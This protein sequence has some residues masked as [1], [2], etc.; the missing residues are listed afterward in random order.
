VLQ[1]RLDRYRQQAEE[2]QAQASKAKHADTK[3]SWLKLAAQWQDLAEEAVRERDKRS[4]FRTQ[5]KR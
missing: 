2:C 1:G 5:E 4:V 3:A